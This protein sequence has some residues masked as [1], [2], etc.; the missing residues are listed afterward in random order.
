LKSL[1]IFHSALRQFFNE[2]GIFYANFKGAGELKMDEKFN[3]SR[4][5]GKTSEKKPLE[6]QPEINRKTKTL[7]WEKFRE[8]RL[9]ATPDRATLTF[10]QGSQV[11][12]IHFDKKRQEIFFRGHNVKNMTLTEEQWMALRQF[13]QYLKDHQVDREMI[14]SYEQCLEQIPPHF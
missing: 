1:T 4:E 10:Y 11:A 14:R 7:G 3:L 8:A 12:S 2:T 9:F 6:A 13:T 5:S